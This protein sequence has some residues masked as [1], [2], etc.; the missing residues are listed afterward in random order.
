M[1]YLGNFYLYAIS[2]LYIHDMIISYSKKIFTTTSTIVFE[3][4]FFF[5]YLMFRAV[6]RFPPTMNTLEWLSVG[7][8]TISE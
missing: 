4:F 6:S 7:S 8:A 2:K 3:F 1:L 5:G